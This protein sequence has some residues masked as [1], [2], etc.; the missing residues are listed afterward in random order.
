MDKAKELVSI[1]VPIYKVEAYIDRCVRSIV[2]QTYEKIEVILVDDGS[3]DE[4]PHMCDKWAMHDSRIKVIH[5]ANEGVAK[6]RNIGIAASSGKFLMFVDSDDYLHETAVEV[7]Y[8]RLKKD[9]SDLAVGQGVHIYDDGRTDIVEKEKM[10]DAT[11]LSDEV[12]N[13]FGSPKY[14]PCYSWAKLYKTELFLGL[15]YPEL[16]CGEDQH[17]WLELIARSKKITTVSDNVYYYY[18]R[19]DSCV[20]NHSDRRYLDSLAAELQ[21]ARFFLE[22]DMLEQARYFFSLS[23]FHAL[24][25]ENRHKA[26]EIYNQK[27]SSRERLLL[28]C[29]DAKTIYRWLSIYYPVLYNVVQW[30]K[31]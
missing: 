19:L 30:L 26:I 24:E 23:I 6:A 10:C 13:M 15:S 14:I 3:P 9:N 4:C 20:H 1:I 31:K 8:N 5:K 2:N 18:Q 29:K 16:I 25:V 7:L 21:C 17:I 12:L 22:H 27:F 28:L 11:Y